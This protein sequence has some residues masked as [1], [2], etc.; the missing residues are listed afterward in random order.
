MPISLLT[1]FQEQA[2]RA[3]AKP[4]KVVEMGPHGE[5][6]LILRVHTSGLKEFYYS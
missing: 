3:K 1:T 5:G 2:L 4:N 6:R